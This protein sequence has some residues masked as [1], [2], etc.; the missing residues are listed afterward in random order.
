MSSLYK[1][2]LLSLISYQVRD[3]EEYKFKPADLVMD[4]C[5]IYI[6]LGKSEAFCLAVSQD[7]RSYNSMLFIQAEKVLG[8]Y[9]IETFTFYFLVFNQ[10]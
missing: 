6:N 1:F 2:V 8:T 5:R 10:V 3:Q 9:H 7:G 4:I